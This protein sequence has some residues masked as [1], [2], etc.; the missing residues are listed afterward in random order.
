MDIL[1]HSDG[2]ES[3][4][5]SGSGLPTGGVFVNY[6]KRDGG[7]QD[8]D[9][10]RIGAAEFMQ[11]AVRSMIEGGQD[12]HEVYRKAIPIFGEDF[13]IEAGVIDIIAEQE[14]K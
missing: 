9:K 1:A 7:S 2:T 11:H 12:P 5:R 4:S 6:L 13:L 8:T 3:Y 10:L 14:A